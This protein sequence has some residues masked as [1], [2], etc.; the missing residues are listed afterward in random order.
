MPAREV[1]FDGLV[2]PTHNYA[3]LSLGNVA[4]MANASAVSNPRAAVKE[5]LA[6]MYALHKLG[7]LQAVVPPPPRPDVATLRRVG[8][9]GS[10]AQVLETCARQAPALLAAVSSASAMW[11]AN[12]C[13]TSPS[14]DSLD[15]RVHFTP[16]N[17]AHQ[18]HR[19][20]ETRDTARVLR[21]IFADPTCFVHHEPLP[22]GGLFGDEGAANHM[23]LCPTH[24]APGTQVFVY[25]REQRDQ[26]APAPR[27]Y[28]ARQ[29]REASEAILRLHRLRPENTVLVHQNPEAIDRGVFHNDVAA[30]ADR[31]VLF[32]HEGAF[33]DTPRALDEIRRAYADGELHV[34][35]VNEREVALDDAV[36]SYLFN[37]QLVSSPNGRTVLIVPRECEEIPAVRN[38]LHGLVA[39]E[40]PIAAVHVIDIR[41][42]MR[43]GG[44]PA[45]LRF[46][47][48]LTDTERAAT[49]AGVFLDEQLYLRLTAWADRHYRDRLTPADLADPDLLEESR[50]AVEEALRILGLG[51]VFG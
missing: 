6:K 2:G 35:L 25:G 13:T 44:G 9:T 1:N 18:F 21:E 23:R 12:A 4:S 7:V 24:G 33:A 29:T 51:P 43:N 31:S 15:G 17:L 3:G 45:C 16:A 11:A 34:V 37:S 47:V 28:P 42:S 27:R 14:C 20:L 19:S 50:R 10:D 8:F 40:G 36:R 30:V 22:S 26:S 39:T 41:Q 46:R 49:R 48:V 32:L 38:Y 5:G